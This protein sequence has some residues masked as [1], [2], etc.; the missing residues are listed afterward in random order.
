MQRMLMQV[1][2]KDKTTHWEGSSCLA[3]YEKC[4]S[5]LRGFSQESMQDFSGS[6][7]AGITAATGRISMNDVEVEKSVDSMSPKIMENCCT[8][9]GVDTVV[10]EVWSDDEV[11]MTMVLDGGVNFSNYKISGERYFAPALDTVYNLDLPS[12]THGGQLSGVGRQQKPNYTVTTKETFKLWFTRVRLQ[13]I[14]PRPCPTPTSKPA[15][16]YSVKGWDAGQN[17]PSDSA[18][19]STA[20]VAATDSAAAIGKQFT[21]QTP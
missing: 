15:A 11:R 9:E 3:G 20:A 4:W 6:G 7:S 12:M 13:V 1:I 19:A 5:E 18:L 17:C 8:G 21:A 2:A 16:T 14:K 10:I